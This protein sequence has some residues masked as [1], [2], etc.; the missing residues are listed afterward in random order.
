MTKAHLKDLQRQ[1]LG[2][3]TD[4]PDVLEHFSTDSSIFQITPS[5]VVYPNNTADVRKTVEF[6]ATRSAA[7]KPTSLVPRG[8]GTDQGGGAIGEGMQVVFPAHMNKLLRIDRDS[9]TVQPGILYKTLQQTLHTHGRFLPP[10]PGSIE[11]STIGG[12]VANNAVG[13]KSVKYGPTRNFVKRLKVV[14]SDG[15]IIETHRISARDLNR[16][17]GLTT[18]EGE[19][20]RKVDSLLLDHP[21]VVRKSQPR[22]AYNSAGYALD[23]V[24]GQDGSFDLSQLIIGSQGTLGLITE[25]TLRTLPYNPRTTVLT[26]NFTSMEKLGEAVVKLRALA[27]SA[28]EMVDQHLLEFL[29]ANRPGEIADLMPE[30]LPKAVLLIE[31]D[32]SSQIAQ[33]LKSTRARRLLAKYATGIRLTTDPLEQVKLWKMRHTAGAVMWMHG[34]SKKAL[35]FIEDAAVPPTR[36]T[37]FLDKTYKLLDKHNLDIAVW[38]HAGDGN[39]HLLPF[40]D[41]SR[42]KDA[43]KLFH[44]AHEFYDIVLS[45]GGSTSGGHNDGLLRSLYLGQMYGEEMFELFASVKHIFDPH[46]IFNP[47]KK[48]QATEAYAREHLRDH[49][50]PMHLYEHI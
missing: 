13:E 27:P 34:G 24:R 6:A 20:Y 22:S 2:S 11:Y 47:M 43:D 19:I 9:V 12:A 31:F 17:K 46:S 30:N 23:K 37:E 1:L 44:L 7:G 8:K 16:K 15:S 48:T 3:V 50:A 40:L 4:N 28:L 14:L 36:L 32:D 33:K 10:Y 35:P 29:R 42:K 38:G 18:L 26:A 49:Y 41:L 25:V 39:L 45:L 5:A 21:D